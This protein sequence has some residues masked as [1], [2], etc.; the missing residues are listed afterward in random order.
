[1]TEDKKP[2]KRGGDALKTLRGDDELPARWAL[3]GAG[4]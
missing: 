1:M 3:R 4:L 2:K